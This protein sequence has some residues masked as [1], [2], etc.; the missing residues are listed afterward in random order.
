[1][2]LISTAL[3]GTHTPL[4]VL[5]H[6]NGKVPFRPSLAV[7]LTELTK[8][9]L[10]TFFL[11]VGWQARPQGAPPWRQDAPFALSALLYGATTT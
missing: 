3:Y 8:L 10:C 5:C 7:L 2:L 1:M 6:V 4:L 11:L 9:L